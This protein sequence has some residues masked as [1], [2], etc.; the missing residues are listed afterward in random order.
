MRPSLLPCED[1]VVLR[2]E[3]AC[4]HHPNSDE[5]LMQ[6]LKEEK[7]QI[8]LEFP[9]AAYSPYREPRICYS[10]TVIR[11]VRSDW[12][13]INCDLNRVSITDSIKFTKLLEKEHSREETSSHVCNNLQIYGY[14]YLGS[15]LQKKSLPVSDD[16][17]G[18]GNTLSSRSRKP[19]K[20]GSY[21]SS[22]SEGNKIKRRR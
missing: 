19:D 18:K 4:N 11:D 14:S 1:C 8:A 10:A 7:N 9:H 17:I 16:K 22:H 13:H 5:A 2:N 20:R 21:L 12:R 3:R 6:R 15:I